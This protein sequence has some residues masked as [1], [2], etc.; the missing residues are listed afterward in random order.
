VLFLYARNVRQVP[1]QQALAAMAVSLTVAILAWAL[2]GLFVG[3]SGKRSLILFLFLLFFHGYGLYF[4]LV[5]GWLPVAARPLLSHGIALLPPL[6]M[7]LALSAAVWR[8]RRD[9]A[10]FNRV[11]QLA[12]MALVAWN[13]FGVL[14][15]AARER[16]SSDLPGQE[17]APGQASSADAPDIYCFVLDEF[18]ALESVRSVFAYDNSALADSLRR[19]GFFVARDSRSRFRLTE[20]AIADILNLGEWPA[21]ADPFSLVRRNAVASFLKR[22]GYRIIEFPVLPALFMETADLRFQYSLG[23]ASIFFDDFYRTLFEATL[24]RV[25]PDVWKSRKS[26][27]SRFY[28][29]RVLHVF[30]RLPELVK[31]PGPKFV[32]IHLYS[33]HEPFVFDTQGGT[34]DAAH[35]WDHADRRYYLGQYRFVSRKIAETAARILRDSAR[36]PV[37]IIQSDH[38]YRGPLR[39][40]ERGNPLPPDEMVRVFN[41]LYLPGVERERIDASLSSLNNFRLVF[42]LYFGTRYP[43]LKNPAGG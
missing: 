43:L 15:H 4:S 32:F 31:S 20:P 10:I 34:V 7:W 42:N 9:F 18:A 2:L 21:G 33:P 40:G 19:L 25:L 14:G 17:S 3:R 35:A 6:C 22:R 12:V 26:D 27:L 13:L 1:P 37:I 24:L 41:A 28:R 23:R 30:A 29:E 16:A 36:P 5:A 8:S 11:L 39:R 38:G